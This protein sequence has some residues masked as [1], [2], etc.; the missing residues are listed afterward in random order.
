MYT[1]R[2]TLK[3]ESRILYEKSMV[4]FNHRNEI[5]SKASELN[6]CTTVGNFEICFQDEEQLYELNQFIAGL[7]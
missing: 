3:G 1:L 2:L 7:R 6:S 4:I 5:F